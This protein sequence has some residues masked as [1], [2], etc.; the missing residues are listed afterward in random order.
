MILWTAIHLPDF[1]LQVFM[2]GAQQRAP[3]A[4]TGQRG[5]L[6]ACNTEAQN[7]GIR[8]GMKLSAAQ[9]L[10]PELETR[11]RD[12]KAEFHALSTLA[13]WCGQWASTISL[14]PPHG[15]LMETGGSVKFFGGIE[16]LTDYMRA[17]LR[18]L[19][20]EHNIASAPTAGSAMMLARAGVT[21]A[22]T[23]PRQLK[24]RLRGLPLELLDYES[25]VLDAL[26][27]MGVRSVGDCLS[28]PRGGL[29]R[30]FGPAL[31][32]QLDRA[33]GEI[34]D[35]RK[36]FNAPL[37]FASRLE[38]P[39]SVEVVEQLVFGLRRL[40]GELTAYLAP[41]SLGVTRLTLELLHDDEDPTVV[42]LGLNA[43]RDPEHLM[44]VLR[45]RLSRV[46][47]PQA[48]VALRLAV[49]E[50]AQLD[51]QTLSL[52]PGERNGEKDRAELIERLRARLGDTAVTGIEAVA[53]HRPERSLR[54]C[55]PAK[56]PLSRGKN[57]R[58]GST[59]TGAGRGVARAA[60]PPPCELDKHRPLWLLPRPQRL[61]SRASRP[62]FDGEVSLIAGPERIASGWWD[63]SDSN[64]DSTRDYFVARA[65][66]GETLW[67]YRHPGADQWYLHGIFS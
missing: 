42:T 35:P 63:D 3:F 49:S 21:T 17:G 23:D 50:T 30:R 43:S 38:L 45:E 64:A 4:V 11:E 40:V 61:H 5:V 12:L 10:Y 16:K 20:Y 34:P 2:R 32:D 57:A 37:S 8:P 52:I 47:L 1:S 9:A 27:A 44:R 51:E 62:W 18:E 19:G 48:V 7:F 13:Q 36:P 6:L 22:V 14:A 41:R 24:S 33:L 28:L 53:D 58:N 59:R 25:D 29:A 26:M 39:S 60:S 55:E 15:V 67:I 31:V 56:S 46:D 66:D 54:N 65:T